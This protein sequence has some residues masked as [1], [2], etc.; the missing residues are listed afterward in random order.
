ML[1]ETPVQTH[2]KPF[3]CAFV[4]FEGFDA[5]D[6]VGPYE[7]LH[8]L[9]NCEVAF[10][11]AR[12][13]PVRNE[14]GDLSLVANDSFE[15]MPTPDL[16][17]VPGGGGELRAREDQALCAWLRAAQAR[18]AWVVSVCTGALVLGAAGLLR[19]R[20]ATT[21][22]LAMDQLAQFGATPVTERYHFEGKLVSSAGVSAGIDMALALAARIASP[23]VAQAIQLGIE[24]DPQPPFETGSP[25]RSPASLV[26]RVRA[27][28]RF[29]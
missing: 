2:Q 5:Q 3:Q 13:G 8:R 21:H 14:R 18:E 27:N 16:V 10:V 17:L 11:A 12:P 1:K 29:A 15:S 19:G 9:P 24:Y 28:S 4:L 23:Q 25:A 26:N 7:V 6:V 22:W 20:R